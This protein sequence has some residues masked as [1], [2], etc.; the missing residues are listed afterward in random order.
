MMTGKMECQPVAMTDI[1]HN[2]GFTSAT[3]MVSQQEDSII[4]NPQVSTP[5]LTSPLSM[6]NPDEDN[7]QGDSSSQHLIS[8]IK[9]S[10]YGAPFGP[11]LEGKN[12]LAQCKTLK[13]CCPGYMSNTMSHLIEQR[14]TP[15]PAEELENV[16]CTIKQAKKL[17]Q[18]NRDIKN[19]QMSQNNMLDE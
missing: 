3:Q 19:Q 13:P 10:N 4:T 16:I 11:C 12:S 9:K 6:S 14:G 17:H 5:V 18:P 15:L 7:A 1:F 2:P 8:E